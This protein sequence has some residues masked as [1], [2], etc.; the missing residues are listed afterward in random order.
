MRRAV[1]VVGGVLAG[2]YALLCALALVLVPA[3]A[4]GWFGL[5]P[6]P[7]GGVFA[8]LLALPWSVALMA[9]SGDRMGLWPAMTIL[10]CGMAVNALALLWLTSGEERRSR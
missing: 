9:L 6:D 1:R 2:I 8:I 5:E 4:E 10:V 7:L 3:S